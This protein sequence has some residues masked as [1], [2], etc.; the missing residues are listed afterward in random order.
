MS[1]YF[2]FGDTAQRIS[3]PLTFWILN[4]KQ[5]EVFSI[6]FPPTTTPE[7]STDMT[8]VWNLTGAGCWCGHGSLMHL[9][10]KSVFLSG[11]IKAASAE[12]NRTNPIKAF[13]PTRICSCIINMIHLNDLVYTVNP[14]AFAD[15]C[16]K[17]SSYN[18]ALNFIFSFKR[19]HYNK[20]Y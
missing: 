13:H 17:N 5:G 9:L 19:I 18:S 15:K 11:A 12:Q 3:L 8:F 6:W 2:L 4:S 1:D 14:I 7:A 20:L 10:T 16:F